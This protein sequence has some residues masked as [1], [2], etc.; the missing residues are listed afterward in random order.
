[1]DIIDLAAVLGA[2]AWTPHVFSVIKK[3]VTKPVVRVITNRTGEIGFTNLGAIFNIRIAFSV[4]NRDIVVSGLKI[5]LV[6]ETGEE[7]IFEWQGIRQQVLK[8]TAP[9]GSVLPYEKEQSVLAI[10]LNQKEIEERFIQC[11]ETAYLNSKYE[12]ESKAVKRLSYLKQQEQ[13]NALE[14]I[15][16]Q[17]MTDLYNFIKHSFSWK[18]GKYFATIELSSPERF[19]IVDNKYEFILTPIDIEELDKNKQNIELDYKNTMVEQN[20]DEYKK[21]VWNWRNPTLRK[22]NN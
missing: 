6:H 5:R 7:K 3:T 15:K 8:M 17:E 18:A 1:M 20:A 19:E 14:F 11:Q 10:K 16:C 12:Y 2:L 22:L 4:E 13:Y 21:A 9:D